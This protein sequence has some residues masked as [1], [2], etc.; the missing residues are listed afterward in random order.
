MSSSTAREDATLSHGTGYQVMFLEAMHSQAIIVNVVTW[1]T[2]PSM[3]G[4]VAG[5]LIPSTESRQQSYRNLQLS[6]R[7]SSVSSSGSGCQHPAHV[8][9]A[10]KPVI[11][12]PP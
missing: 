12:I 4:A 5:K 3:S 7:S 9:V 2:T 8:G 6:S 1:T 11:I 10:N